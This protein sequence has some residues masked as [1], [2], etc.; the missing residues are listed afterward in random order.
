MKISDLKTAR[1][2]HEEASWQVKFLYAIG[3]VPNQAQ[4]LYLKWRIRHGQEQLAGR[5][6]GHD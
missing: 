3:W 2:L 5:R 1:Q 6:A 4:I